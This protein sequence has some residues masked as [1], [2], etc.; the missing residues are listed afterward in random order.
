[1]SGIGLHQQLIILGAIL[2][3]KF[4]QKRQLLMKENIGIMQLSSVLKKN[5]HEANKYNIKIVAFTM[6]GLPGEKVENA[7]ETIEMLQNIKQ[8][9]YSSQI[10]HSYIG[11]DIT[12]Q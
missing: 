10:F 1:L 9:S 2:W 12:T 11:L 6:F 7:M 3:Q 4:I 8:Y 5:N